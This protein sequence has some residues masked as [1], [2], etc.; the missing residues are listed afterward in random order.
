VSRRVLDRLL[1][2]AALGIVALVAASALAPHFR[3]TDREAAAE[4]AAATTFTTAPKPDPTSISIVVG[5]SDIALHASPETTFLRLC[6]FDRLDI[7]VRPG[8]RL[9]LRYDGPPCHLPELDLMAAVRDV[10]GDYVHRVEALPPQA[11]PPNLAGR[12]TLST[13]LLP[14]LLRCWSGRPL[15]LRVNLRGTAISGTIRCRVHP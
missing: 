9:V 12:Q 4:R 2:A 15:G 10:R 3:H 6:R 5:H 1:I 7:G 13:P 8:P 11:F 14:G